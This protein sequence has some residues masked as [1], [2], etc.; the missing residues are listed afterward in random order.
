MVQPASFI[1]LA[2]EMGTIVPIGRWVLDEACRQLREWHDRWPMRRDL[3]MSGNISRRQLG[4]RGIVDDRRSA[5]E[6]D[7]IHP[8]PLNIQITPKAIMENPEAP[9]PPPP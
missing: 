5:P 9:E 1:P 7:P 3:S 8:G 2:E 6:R 4:G